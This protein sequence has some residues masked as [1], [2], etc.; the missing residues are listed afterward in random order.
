MNR[1]KGFSLM[2]LITA[3]VIVGILAAVSYPPYQE[4]VRKARRAEAQGAL[5]SLAQAMERFYTSKRTYDGAAAGGAAT[6]APEIFPTKSPISGSNAY[7]NLKIVS[8]GS[9]AYVVA[10]E[11]I[12]AQ[13]GDGV[14]VLKSTG[15]QGW[16]VDNDANGLVS[17]LGASPNEVESSEWCW[18]VHC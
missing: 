4:S 18:T 8:A 7:Y 13:A 10:A 11:P 2:E 12:N 9:T 15:A 16:D 14:L 1:D 3:L 6:G 5:Q 17:G